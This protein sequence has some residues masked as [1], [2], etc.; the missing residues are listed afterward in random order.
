VGVDA[1]LEDAGHGDLVAADHA[2]EVLHRGGGRHHLE[3]LGAAARPGALAA[4]AAGGE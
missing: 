2:D 4:T 1:R 3:P